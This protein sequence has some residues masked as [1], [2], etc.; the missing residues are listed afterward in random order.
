M[1]TFVVDFGNR[2]TG[3]PDGSN[4][5]TVLSQNFEIEEGGVVVFYGEPA[6]SDSI[7]RLAQKER[8]AAF[9]EWA[10]IRRE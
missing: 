9:S 10:A 3:R 1:T 8:M 4:T 5:E 2:E 7:G 6:N